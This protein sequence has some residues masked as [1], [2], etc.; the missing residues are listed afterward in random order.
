M[1]AVVRCVQQTALTTGYCCYNLLAAC[2][3]AR[4]A[5]SHAAVA[6][7]AVQ[8]VADPN[9]GQYSDSNAAAAV[10]LVVFAGL[11]AML[12][13]VGQRQVAHSAAVCLLHSWSQSGR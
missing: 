2:L 7:S 6:A 12:L 9:A 4:R 10:L 5:A 1:F 3:P 8:G 13:L 11:A